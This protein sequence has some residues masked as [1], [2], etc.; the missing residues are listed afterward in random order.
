MYISSA[1]R[2]WLAVLC[3]LAPTLALALP[4]IQHWETKRG[5]RAYFVQA[6][7]LP[8]LDVQVIFDAGSARDGERPGIATL[9]ASLLDQGAAEMDADA[10]SA[11]F[12]S[13]GAQ[14]YSGADRDSATVGVRTMTGRGALPQ[15]LDT[16]RQV[17]SL[18]NFPI[19]AIQRQIR[20][21]QTGIEAKQQSP[22]A[23]ARDA[24]Q[25]AL[26]EGH[27]YAHPPEGTKESLQE[28]RREHIEAFYQDHYVT[29]NALLVM[30]G[31]ISKRQAKF[32]ADTLFADM[33]IGEQAPVLP[34]VTTEKQA[35]RVAIPFPSAQTHVLLGQ[36]GIKRS[37]PDYFPL[38]VGNHVL[39]G[40]GMVSR[41]FKEIREQRGLSYAV[42]SYFVPRRESG[43]FIANLQTREDQ[44]EAALSLL[45]E[46]IRR[47]T[48]NGPSEE[49]LVL[50]KKNLT[51][52]FPLKIDSNRDIL[53]YVAMIALNRLPLDYLDRFVHRI[54]AVDLEQ[55]RAAFQRHLDIQRMATITVGGDTPDS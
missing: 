10:I 17:L 54:M 48:E 20:R 1:A 27:P 50:A 3:M 14:F 19:D 47:Y 35:K 22:G 37:D 36:I 52:G 23:L 16:L 12:E 38:Y 7:E 41:L 32:I 8:M 33:A 43:F 28:I 25:R 18:A 51:G 45:I 15:T 44:A 5:V 21:T 34:A 2:L 30:V 31:D 13:V 24:L 55:V 6:P 11:Q 29:K 46:N 53:Q 49:E 40:N 9:T 39:G 42:Y 26:Y 4:Q